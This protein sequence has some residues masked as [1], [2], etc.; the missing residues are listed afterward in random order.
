MVI[1]ITINFIIH[2]LHLDFTIWITVIKVDI[3][4]TK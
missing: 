4:I 3:A 2:Y 1:V